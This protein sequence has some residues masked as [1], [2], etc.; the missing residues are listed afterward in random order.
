MDDFSITCHG[1]PLDESTYSI[2]LENKVFNTDSS[3]L[4]LDFSGL[5]GWTFNTGSNCTFRTGH[6]CTF[7]TGSACTFRTGWDCTFDT[8][9][10][11]TFRTGNNCTFNTGYNCAFS[12]FHINSCTF[13]YN[14]S[15]KNS[16]ILDRTDNKHYLLTKEFVQL[17]KIRNG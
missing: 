6:N 1:K 10:G 15:G 2:D 16:I 4:V 14:E 11:C 3:N 8:Y 9:G 17:R 5:G 13:M 12:V 7:K